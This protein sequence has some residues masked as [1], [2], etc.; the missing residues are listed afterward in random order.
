MNFDKNPGGFGAHAGANGHQAALRPQGAERVAIGIAAENRA[1]GHLRRNYI[2]TQTNNNSVPTPP[3]AG[4]PTVPF[5]PINSS[6]DLSSDYLNMLADGEF[7][8]DPYDNYEKWGLDDFNLNPQQGNGMPGSMIDPSLGRSERPMNGSQSAQPSA[9]NYSGPSAPAP[10]S[11]AF[12]STPDTPKPYGGPFVDSTTM[13]PAMAMFTGPNQLNT[14][15]GSLDTFHNSNRQSMRGIAHESEFGSNQSARLNALSYPTNNAGLS[16][17]MMP[18][19]VS[20]L[21]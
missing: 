9:G 5:S 12:N 3:N 8:D 1:N 2:Q 18:S 11:R 21:R 7:L 10:F 13:Q 19:M 14:P 20:T 17:A 16:P 6:D 15:H 4:D